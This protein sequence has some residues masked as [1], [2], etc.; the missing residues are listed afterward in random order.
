M[1]L[2]IVTPQIVKGDG[3]GRANYEV[4]KAAL[5]QGAEITLVTSQL[6]SDLQ[7]NACINWIALPLRRLPTKLLK[8]IDFANR[9]AAWVNKH[10]AMFD[11]V[12]V[13]G[14]VTWATGDIN[15]AHFIHHAWLRS[16]VHPVRSQRNPYGFYQWLYS[17]LNAH[18]E[19]PAFQQAQIT[20]AVSAKV[21]QELVEIGVKSESIH[22]IS[23]GVDLEEFYPGNYIS[24]EIALRR[25]SWNLPASVP[26]A[27]FIGDIRLKRKNLD[28]VLHALRQV[29]QLHLAVVG[30]VE[31]SP[32]PQ[33]AEELGVTQRV[34]FLDFQRNIADLMRI[35]DLFVF[36]SHYEPFGMVVLEAM[37]CGLP[38]VITATIGAA[39]VINPECGFVL[40]ISDDRVALAQVLQQLVDDP[41]L[42]RRMGQAGRAIAEQHSWSS[43]ARQYLQLFE[44][45]CEQKA[46]T[47]RLSVKGR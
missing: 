10:R 18:W 9:S 5:E 44:A 29:P 32:Y 27:L 6:A 31:G 17:K 46:A 43:K 1:K 19:R 3:Q 8:D 30:R 38:V 22:I 13:N 33:M 12:M 28:T 42:G 15:A 47:D 41:E 34:H 16:S 25:Q 4:V 36:P 11:L 45:F 23:N 39:E 40:P 20:I 26:L 24:E 14:C 7:Q 2:C 21:G 37:A 35:A